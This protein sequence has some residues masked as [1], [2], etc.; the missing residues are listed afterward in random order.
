M[1]LHISRTAAAG[2]IGTHISPE[3]F[4]PMRSYHALL[5]LGL[6]FDS[7]GGVLVFGY[8]LQT[9][10]L[11]NVRD[12]PKVYPFFSVSPR[13]VKSDAISAQIGSEREKLKIR[14]SRA[15]KPP[16]FAYLH[17]SDPFHPSAHEFASFGTDFGFRVQTKGVTCFPE[18][19][20][21]SVAII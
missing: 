19:A 14:G 10:V 8:P 5:W 18:S 13:N 1:K 16:I 9:Q 12:P 11:R 3:P 15:P 4:R 6:A 2:A 21:Y 7:D 20:S 17:E